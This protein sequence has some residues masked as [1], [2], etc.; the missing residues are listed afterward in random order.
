M[1]VWCEVFV[2]VCG[3]SV[4]MC[5]VCVYVSIYVWYM[6]VMCGMVMFLVCMWYVWSVCKC[7]LHVLGC[8]ILTVKLS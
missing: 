7:M 1:C 6:S 2:Y 5:V 3:V 4:A 8:F